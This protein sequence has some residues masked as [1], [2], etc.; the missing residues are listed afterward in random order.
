M[1]MKKEKEGKRGEG[2]F[3]KGK[4]IWDLDFG[5]IVVKKETVKRF[6]YKHRGSVRMALSGICTK[7]D[8]EKRKRE[9]LNQPLP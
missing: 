6:S 5:A 7:E 1:A 2:R 8:F 4:D 3:I 9:V